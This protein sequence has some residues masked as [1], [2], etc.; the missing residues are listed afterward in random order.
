MKIIKPM[1]Y[2]VLSAFLISVIAFFVL[3]SQGNYFPEKIEPVEIHRVSEAAVERDAGTSIT[4]MS[5]NIQ[6]MAGNQNNHFFYD[7]GEDAWP[8]Q[9]TYTKTLQGVAQVINHYSPDVVLLQEVDRNCT[10]SY[11]VDQMKA[12]SVRLSTDYQWAVCAPDWLSF[13]IPS[14]NIWGRVHSS[15][16]T[17]SK[18]PLIHAQRYA[19]PSDDAGVSWISQPF[20]PQ[21]AVLQTSIE[22]DSLKLDLWNTH[23]SHF[24]KKYKTKKKQLVVL[25]Q[26]LKEHTLPVVLGGDFNQLPSLKWYDQIYP[27][28]RKLFNAHEDELAELSDHW[29]MIPKRSDFDSDDASRW[30]TYMPP[31]TRDQIADRALDYFFMTPQVKVEDYR[32]I[33][34][35]KTRMLSDHLPL[36]VKI[37][38]EK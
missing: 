23:L 33:N 29:Q 24:D 38:L 21:R 18:L 37:S 25:N 13:F 17:F 16:C 15:I 2:L 31:E 9:E 35:Q 11:H 22:Y 30:F 5:W 8:D 6:F 4:V 12:L 34:T 32:V 1:L 26:L 14:S 27:A 3:R 20:Y 19:L 10:R 28:H 7:D 36:L